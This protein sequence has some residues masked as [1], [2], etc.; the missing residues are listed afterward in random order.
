MF[1]LIVLAV[2]ACIIYVAIKRS[3]LRASISHLP[4]TFIVFDLE[5]TGLDCERHE[6][7]EIGAIR[8]SRDST[9]HVTFQTLVR[10]TKRIPALI[11]N[12]TGITQTMVDSDGVPLDQAVREFIGFI[13]DSRLVA[14]NAD[15]DMGFI[16]CAAAKQN[17]AISNQVSCAL[18]MARRA[19][20]GRRSYRLDDLSAD[21]NLGTDGAHRA[22]K[23]SERAL[24]VY[25]SAAARLGTLA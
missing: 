19:F 3:R 11:T 24:I 23:D 20:P 10:P 5:T 4:E 9:T 22:L 21:G 12:K 18:K 7:I 17:L 25:A 8:V 6:I 1:W 13:G 2:L 16:R 15:F 14:F